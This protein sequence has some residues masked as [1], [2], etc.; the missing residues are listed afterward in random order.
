[1]DFEEEEVCRWEVH[2]DIVRQSNVRVKGRV[3]E[4]DDK[5]GWSWKNRRLLNA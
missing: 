4:M 5:S 3:K 2:F 1:V